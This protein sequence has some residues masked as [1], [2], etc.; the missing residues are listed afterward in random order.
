MK[1]LIEQIHAKGTKSV[2]FP[3]RV[4]SIQYNGPQPR[5]PISVPKKLFKRAVKRNLI[6][7]RIREAFR[8]LT[9]EH[10]EWRKDKAFLIVYI[11]KDISDYETIKSALEAVLEK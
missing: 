11:S 2:S 8:Q 3:L 4:Y 9:K 10:P 1:A 7:R 6:R 5:I